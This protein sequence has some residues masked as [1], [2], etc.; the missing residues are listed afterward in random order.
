MVSYLA[1]LAALAAVLPAVFA[2]PT[3]PAH[4]KVR[5][6]TERDVIKDSYIIVYNTDVNK[7]MRASHIST[8]SSIL[9]KRASF[10]GVGAKWELSTLK[11]YQLT[12]DAATIAEIANFPEV[13]APPSYSALKVKLTTKRLPTSRKTPKS[14]H[15]L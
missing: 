1:K 5:N 8:V 3:T 12:A 7:T 13:S 4:L 2:A 6:P 9:G 11:G 15:Q 14:M 10:G